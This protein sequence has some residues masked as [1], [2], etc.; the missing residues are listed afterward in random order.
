MPLL[1]L[2]IC[3]WPRLWVE[4]PPCPVVL[5]LLA[6]SSPGSKWGCPFLTQVSR[7]VKFCATCH[8]FRSISIKPNS[9]DMTLNS[10]L[11]RQKLP[12]RLGG[13]HTH[14]HSQSGRRA[15]L[16][17][18]G[19]E[20]SARIPLCVISKSGVPR[21]IV[22]TW[23]GPNFTCSAGAHQHTHYHSQT[24]TSQGP[25]KDFLQPVHL[26]RRAPPL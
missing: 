3:S 13:M 12:L 8:G 18:T 2:P 7:A 25:G 26:G 16:N 21:G 14:P 10:R 23:Q 22:P 17:K 4:D 24:E 20:G 6:L 15:S 19:K 11:N 9:T 1:C 5:I